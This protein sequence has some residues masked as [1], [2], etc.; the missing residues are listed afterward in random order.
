MIIDFSKLNWTYRT[1]PLNVTRATFTVY[2]A[3]SPFADPVADV[4][5]REGDEDIARLLTNAPRLLASLKL[6]RAAVNF[7]AAATVAGDSVQLLYAND[8]MFKALD[9]ATALIAEVE[10]TSS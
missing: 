10:G 2:M 3:D 6:L 1:A 4:M 8:R 7:R 5:K 9:G